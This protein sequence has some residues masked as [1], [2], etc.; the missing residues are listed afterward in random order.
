MSS[1]SCGTKSGS[2]PSQEYRQ[3]PRES[4]Q[5]VR[6]TADRRLYWWEKVGIT[7]GGHMSLAHCKQ[8]GSSGACCWYTAMDTRSMLAALARANHTESYK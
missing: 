2:G 3:T 8:S 4:T 5:G 1:S 7:W 6:S